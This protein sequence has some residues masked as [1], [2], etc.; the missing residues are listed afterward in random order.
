MDDGYAVRVIAHRCPE[1]ADAVVPVQVLAQVVE[2]VDVVNARLLAL[3]VDDVDAG[4]VVGGEHGPT[5]A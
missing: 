4:N 2:V 5:L 3:Q 1:I